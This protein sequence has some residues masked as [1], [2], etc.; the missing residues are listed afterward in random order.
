MRDLIAEI[1]LARSF[2]ISHVPGQK[3]IFGNELADFLASQAC[4]IGAVRQ[5]HLSV[6]GSSSWRPT[7]GTCVPDGDG[8]G[9]CGSPSGPTHQDAPGDGHA[10]GRG[11]ASAG[12]VCSS[13]VD[14][15]RT[16]GPGI[17]GIP[18]AVPGAA[19]S[20]AAALAG[21]GPG[22]VAQV[23]GYGVGESGALA[24]SWDH[25]HLAFSTPSA[26]TTT[27][28]RDVLRLFK[29]NIDPASKGTPGTV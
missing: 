27:P 5:A 20:Y 13:D 1:S 19:R 11:G 6:P 15:G 22:T 17:P 10:A 23:R 28:V 7:A 25:E 3:G 14:V 21:S 16:H 18:P 26:Q 29:T 9:C 8:A 4:R 12:L 24:P 2:R